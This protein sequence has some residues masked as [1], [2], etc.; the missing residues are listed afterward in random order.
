M[1]RPYEIYDLGWLLKV[2]KILKKWIF[3]VI[4]KVHSNAEAFVFV[5]WLYF[6]IAHSFQDTAFQGSAILDQHKI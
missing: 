3:L 6:F 2:L 4:F 1:V 5:K